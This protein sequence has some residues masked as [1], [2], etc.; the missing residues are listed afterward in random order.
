MLLYV[1]LSLNFPF[2]DHLKKPCFQGSKLLKQI[3]VLLA[4]VLELVELLLEEVRVD[5]V[6][7]RLLGWLNLVEEGLDVASD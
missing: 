1:I 2:L 6:Q 4:F 5:L 7:D 3:Q